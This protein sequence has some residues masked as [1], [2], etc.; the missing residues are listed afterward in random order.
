M[1]LQ[2]LFP[3]IFHAERA[4]V[5]D[6]NFDR[7]TPR[8][9]R[10]EMRSIDMHFIHFRFGN[11]EFSLNHCIPLLFEVVCCVMVHAYHVMVMK[12]CDVSGWVAASS[13]CSWPP[14]VGILNVALV[15]SCPFSDLIHYMHL[16]VLS[17]DRFNWPCC[18]LQHLALLLLFF[19][20]LGWDIARDYDAIHFVSCPTDV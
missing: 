6:L 1:L 3:V 2:S 5:V 4:D 20:S 8:P 16:Q 7:L 18:W 11:L 15:Y 13:L 9:Q 10:F 17:H 19:L 12:H 14:D